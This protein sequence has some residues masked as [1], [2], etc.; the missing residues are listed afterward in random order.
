[1]EEWV[2]FNCPGCG[3]SLKAKPDMAGKRIAV[4]GDMAELG[5][6]SEAAHREIGRKT[7]ELNVDYLVTAGR[8]AD[9]TAAAARAAGLDAI[10]AVSDVDSAAKVLKEVMRPGDVVLLKASRASGFERLGEALKS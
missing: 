9:E 5:E 6:E 7:A 10:Q 4:L 3:K 2:R 8:W 1:M